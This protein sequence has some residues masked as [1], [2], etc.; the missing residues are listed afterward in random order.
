M[1]ERRHRHQLL[2]LQDRDQPF[3]PGDLIEGVEVRQHDRIEGIRPGQLRDH[4]G[5]E[6][7]LQL[8]PPE[9]L[10]GANTGGNHAQLSLENPYP[11]RELLIL[12]TNQN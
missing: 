3:A 4:R 5:P 7:R 2:T 8:I 10:G 6:H 11:T 1:H 9:H 12:T